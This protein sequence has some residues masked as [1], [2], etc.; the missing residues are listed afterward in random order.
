MQQVDE[1]INTDHPRSLNLIRESL[2]KECLLFIP[3]DAWKLLIQV[4]GKG[5]KKFTDA[6]KL[7]EAQLNAGQPPSPEP[8]QTLPDQAETKVDLLSQEPG[9]TSIPDSLVPTRRACSLRVKNLSDEH[10][11]HVN[12]ARSSC[13][14]HVSYLNPTITVIL[15]TMGG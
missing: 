11:R 13:L 3:K 1:D 12:M 14:Q 10:F 2:K 7:L 9:D 5:I 8:T 15:W 4:Y 6:Q